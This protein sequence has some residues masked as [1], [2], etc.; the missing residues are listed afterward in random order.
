MTSTVFLVYLIWVSI[1][2]FE[3]SVFLLST[4]G[5][6]EKRIA[7]LSLGCIRM[8][9]MSEIGCSVD[10]LM[11][12]Q[13]AG[14]KQWI[15]TQ[16]LDWLSHYGNSSVLQNSTF[17]SFCFFAL[18]FPLS[19]LSCGLPLHEVRAQVCRVP[20]FTISACLLTWGQHLL[21][22]QVFVLPDLSRVA[23]YATPK[24]DCRRSGHA[25][26][27]YVALA[28]WW[29]WAEAF[30]KQQEEAFSVLPVSAWRQILQ[31]ELSCHQSPPW[32]F[33]QPGKKDAGHRRDQKS[34]PPPD[35]RGHKPSDLTSLPRAHSP[36]LKVTDSPLT[37]L[38]PP[39]LCLL[40]WNLILN[41]MSPWG[42]THFFLGFSHVYLGDTC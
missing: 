4:E 3:S 19:S 10:C 13:R 38:P 16:A 8:W 35:T 23:E 7:T 22:E 39:P 31:K 2:W 15:L 14:L 34:S 18:L 27:K 30:G 9:G 12:E 36:F 11:R 24:H 29:F 37:G 41:L 40:K 28:Y 42:V 21:T 5:N 17:F 26:Q 32:E 6:L 33:H 1:H 25:T 20:H